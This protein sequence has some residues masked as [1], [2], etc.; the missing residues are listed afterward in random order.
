ME[1]SNGMIRITRSLLDMN[2][3]KSKHERESDAM[4][5]VTLQNL[6]SA[7]LASVCLSLSQLSANKSKLLTAFSLKCLKLY[8][9]LC[10]QREIKVNE[11]LADEH[12]KSVYH[13]FRLA[14]SFND[15]VKAFDRV[16]TS[17]DNSPAESEDE[18]DD[19]SLFKSSKPHLSKKRKL[20][21]NEKKNRK[22]VR[23]DR[24]EMCIIKDHFETILE[25]V[26]SQIKLDDTTLD[27]LSKLADE[28]PYEFTANIVVSITKAF[29]SRMSGAAVVSAAFGAIRAF[30]P[31][32]PNMDASFATAMEA[33][34]LNQTHPLATV[35]T[36]LSLPSSSSK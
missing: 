25:D 11:T 22:R 36:S 32:I 27:E 18:D 31:N 23:C 34:A 19:N 5:M 10:K 33:A 16:K 29:R 17:P 20:D 35:Q 9:S 21:H 28:D 15:L 12:A 24:R 8:S 7:P 14:D 3:D 1:R 4:K 2:D 30:I 26:F 13:D 6:K